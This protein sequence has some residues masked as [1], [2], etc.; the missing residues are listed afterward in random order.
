[1]WR[2]IEITPLFFIAAGVVLMLDSAGMFPYMLFAAVLHELGHISA[3]KLCGGKI[4]KLK[5]TVGGA[6]I[7]SNLFPLGYKKELLVCLAG[8]AASIS[9]AVVFAL[10]ARI[11]PADISPL[12]P[13]EDFPIETF[14]HE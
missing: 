7:V 3:I 1:M 10:A 13:I 11:L 2:K 9:C 4:G 14:C 12:C 8:P 6:E 5:I